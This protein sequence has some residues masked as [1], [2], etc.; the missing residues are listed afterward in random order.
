MASDK[1]SYETTLWKVSVTDIIS[2][3]YC[4][5]LCYSVPGVIGM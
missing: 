5:S 1:G 3:S 4:A 2:L